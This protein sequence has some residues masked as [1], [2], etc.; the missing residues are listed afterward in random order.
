MIQ[1]ADA[2]RCLRTGPLGEF[3]HCSIGHS[4]P[5]AGL[6]GNESTNAAD[7]VAFAACTG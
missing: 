4:Y 5:T 7:E 2:N 6:G 3:A 1:V